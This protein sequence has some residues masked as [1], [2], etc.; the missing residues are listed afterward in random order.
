MAEPVVIV[1]AGHAGLQAASTLRQLGYEGSIKL[2]GEEAHLPYHRPPLSKSFLKD[3]AASSSSIVLRSPGF[4]A[5]A[6]VDWLAGERAILIDP[7]AKRLT[8]QSGAHVGYSHLVLATGARNRTLDPEYGDLKN[9]VS[10]R[11]L[12]DALQLRAALHSSSSIVIIGGG[13]IGL[14]VA[15]TA[16]KLG[17]D[18]TVVERADRLMSRV[19]SPTLSAY[20]ARTHEAAGVRL[21]LGRE[22]I[23]VAVSGTRAAGVALD[24]GEFIEADLIVVGIGSVP[25]VELAKAAGLRVGNGILV[26]SWLRTDAGH[27]SAIGDCAALVPV[28]GTAPIRL[29]S[30]QNAN[31][32]ARCI[33]A[34]LTGSDAPY[35]SVPWFWS[36]QTGTKLQIAGLLNGIDRS[37]VTGDVTGANFS[38]LNFARGRLACVESINRPTDHMAARRLVSAETQLDQDAVPPNFDLSA[39]LRRQTTDRQ[40]LDPKL[41]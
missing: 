39:F 6:S 12:D 13:F 19:V 2:V 35:N 17:K 25:N 26:D 36:D 5:D 31:D 22:I 24:T 21:R 10:L 40:V 29:E 8:L 3:P 20:F 34:Q 9:V 33:A 23:K 18:V 14:E 27:V 15:S 4:F 16:I 38:V 1:G 11:S 32:Q 28:D 41:T 37:I 30:I 7:A